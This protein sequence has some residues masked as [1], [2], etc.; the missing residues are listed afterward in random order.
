TGHGCA[1]RRSSRADD[2]WDPAVRMSNAI[3]AIKPKDDPGCVSLIRTRSRAFG[4]KA[5]D[6]RLFQAGDFSR[7]G[8]GI[9]T[10]KS[11]T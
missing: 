9:K 4:L 8:R 6:S 2:A 10:E 7:S 5:V 11:C 1:H 3:S